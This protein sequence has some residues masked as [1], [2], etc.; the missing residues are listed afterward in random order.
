[1]WSKSNRFSIGKEDSRDFPV[2]PSVGICTNAP[3]VKIVDN[4]RVDNSSPERSLN[5]DRSIQSLDNKWSARHEPT[6]I[7]V[8]ID[9]PVNN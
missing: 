4:W 6:D 3:T 5:H 1:M 9:S 7:L 8:G 2:F